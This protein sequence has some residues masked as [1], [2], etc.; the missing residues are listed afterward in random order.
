MKP[1]PDYKLEPP[2]EDSRFQRWMDRLTVSEIVDICAEPLIEKLW[3]DGDER[4]TE[5]LWHYYE[6]MGRE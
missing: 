1:L 6:G 2:D 4:V 3:F 5:C